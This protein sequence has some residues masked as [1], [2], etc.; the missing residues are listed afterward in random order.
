MPITFNQP[1][2]VFH[3]FQ[4]P[5]NRSNGKISAETIPKSPTI[6]KLPTTAQ[7]HLCSSSY[8]KDLLDGF[9]N[10]QQS[11]Q[12]TDV[13]LACDGNSLDAHKII[14]SVASSYFKRLFESNPCKHPIIFLKD[15]KFNHL[16]IIINF[17][18][19]GEMIVNDED[20]THV[21]NL[22]EQLDIRGLHDDFSKLVRNV[23]IEPIDNE[24]EYPN[25]LYNPRN[26]VSVNSRK[27]R[28]A[29]LSDYVNYTD[30]LPII[31]KDTNIT[32]HVMPNKQ[33]EVSV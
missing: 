8:N 2:R 22:A 7:Y 18:Y 13:T 12:L 29:S 1:S 33:I 4:S 3:T 32:N 20:L 15:V 17:I 31:P 9:S 24:L 16:I 5:I 14:L 26:S 25:N 6:R 30:N 10:S 28:C 23:S 11:G 27:R 21:I 19:K